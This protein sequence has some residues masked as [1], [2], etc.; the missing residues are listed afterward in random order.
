MSRKNTHPETYYI[1][2]EPTAKQDKLFLARA[3]NIFV[4]FALIFVN[5]TFNVDIPE[6][7]WWLFGGAAT[8]IEINQFIEVFKRWKKA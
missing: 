3:S 4:L 1:T 6:S 2:V 8:G 5:H 7:L